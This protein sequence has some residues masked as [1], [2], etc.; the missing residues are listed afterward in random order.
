[1]SNADPGQF[2]KDPETL[3]KGEEY[4]TIT[5]ELA[6]SGTKVSARRGR[7]E[8]NAMTYEKIFRT[9][10]EA[11]SAAEDCRIEALR[12]GFNPPLSPYVTNE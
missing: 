5:L 8:D 3:W 12:E 1:M 9:R 4:I 10:E 6:P 2:V 7:G 11:E